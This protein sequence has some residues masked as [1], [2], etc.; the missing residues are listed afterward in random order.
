MLQLLHEQ[1][2]HA[3]ESTLIEACRNRLIS[4]IN[5]HRKMHAKIIKVVRR[6]CDICSRI[7]VTRHS[8][9]EVKNHVVK[10]IGDFVSTDLVTMKRLVLFML[11]TWSA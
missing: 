5:L 11:L 1:T 3:N 10:E 4:G 2:G 7:K 6:K 8:I 9:N